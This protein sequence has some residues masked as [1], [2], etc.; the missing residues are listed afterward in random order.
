MTRLSEIETELASLM[1]ERQELNSLLAEYRDQVNELETAD[2]VNLAGVP[3]AEM[4]VRLVAMAEADRNLPRLRQAVRELEKRE[5]AIAMQWSLADRARHRELAVM[6]GRE[7]AAL[8]VDSGLAN[9]LQAVDAALDCWPN[10]GTRHLTRIGRELTN[11]RVALQA[12]LDAANTA[13]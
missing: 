10:K 3:A 7:A 11:A 13:S 12:L 1:A 6:N 4:R 9:M 2:A 5:R 8:L